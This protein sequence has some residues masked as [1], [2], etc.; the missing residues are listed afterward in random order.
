LIEKI[1]GELTP[2]KH[3]IL[4]KILKENYQGLC[5]RALY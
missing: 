1:R 3:K 4:A 2:E 5:R